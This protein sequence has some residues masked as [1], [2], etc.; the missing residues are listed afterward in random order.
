MVIDRIATATMYLIMMRLAVIK[1]EDDIRVYYVMLFGFLFMVDFVSHFFHVSH[2]Y[3]TGEQTH[4]EQKDTIL[5]IYYWKPCLTITVG[6]QEFFSLYIYMTFFPEEFAPLLAHEYVSYVFYTSIAIG[7]L[8]KAWTN[9]LHLINSLYGISEVVDMEKEW[10]EAYANGEIDS[11]GEEIEAEQTEEEE[12]E[13][14]GSP[15]KVD[16]QKAN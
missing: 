7:V 3:A 6:L 5:K 10:D 8:F 2:V 13:K 12:E 15:A 4:K 14:I 1:T 16:R 11:Y 9:Y